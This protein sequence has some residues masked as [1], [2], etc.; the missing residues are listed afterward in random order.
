MSASSTILPRTTMKKS[1]IVHLK[2]HSEYTA[3]PHTWWHLK[4]GDVQLHTYPQKLIQ[5]CHPCGIL[6]NQK[7]CR[8]CCQIWIWSTLHKIP[9]SHNHPQNSW[10]TWATTTAHTDTSKK[11]YSSKSFQQNHE[12]IN[13]M[14]YGY[15]NLLGKWQGCIGKSPRILD[16]QRILKTTTPSINQ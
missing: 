7:Y 8:L 6:A 3:M 10:G 9:N 1:D 14:L 13:V 11:I 12:K 2:L 4:L 15:E 5:W 16:S